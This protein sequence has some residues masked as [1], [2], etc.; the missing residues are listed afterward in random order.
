LG[1]DQGEIEKLIADGVAHAPSADGVGRGEA[2]AKELL[3]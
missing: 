1:L 3:A 2:A